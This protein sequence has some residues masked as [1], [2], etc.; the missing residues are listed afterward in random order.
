MKTG[1]A[2]NQL[3]LLTSSTHVVLSLQ[4]LFGLNQGIILVAV[5]TPATLSRGGRVGGVEEWKVNS[6]DER[7]GVCALCMPITVL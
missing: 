3:I 4:Q 2:R 5:A 7:F 1:Y 6:I